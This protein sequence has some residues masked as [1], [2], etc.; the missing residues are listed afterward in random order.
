MS[1]MQALKRDKDIEELAK[2]D[3]PIHT[4]EPVATTESATAEETKPVIDIFLNPLRLRTRVRARFFYCPCGDI[5][6]ISIHF[7]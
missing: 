3:K 2:K 5:K 6:C 4:E 1:P 7:P